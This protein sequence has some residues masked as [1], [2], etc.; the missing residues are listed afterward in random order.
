M[1]FHRRVGK[2]ITLTNSNRTAMRNISEFNHG[3]VLS[4]DS[5]ID[6]KLFEVRIDEKVSFF[7]VC[8]KERKLELKLQIH[9]WSGSIEIG[10]T[11]I[12]PETVELPACATKLRSGTW[13]MS[14]I[15]VLKDGNSLVEYYGTDLDKLKEGDRIGVMKTSQ[16]CFVT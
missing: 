5:L 3:L 1:S 9:G 8:V 14:G 6:D 4:N 16:V 13:V 12:N 2:R 10:V 11:T 15:S 7:F